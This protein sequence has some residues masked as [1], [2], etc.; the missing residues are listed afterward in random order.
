MT[1][2]DR[3][4]S[5]S[6]KSIERQVTLNFGVQVNRQALNNEHILA[7]RVLSHRNPPDFGDAVLALEPTDRKIGRDDVRPPRTPA[8]SGYQL[9]G[10]RSASARA[11]SYES[12][13]RGFH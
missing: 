5:A 3:T 1:T 6:I 10:A 11:P 7:M 2:A 4:R 8:T 9:P 12:G 13:K